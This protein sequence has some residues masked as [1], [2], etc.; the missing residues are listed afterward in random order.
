[1]GVFTAILG[2]SLV[3]AGCRGTDYVVVFPGFRGQIGRRHDPDEGHRAIL[4]PA[5]IMR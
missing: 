2:V 1:M 4:Y 5:E 3:A